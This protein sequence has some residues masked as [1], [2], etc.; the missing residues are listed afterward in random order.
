MNH[1][2]ILIISVL[3]AALAFMALTDE[4]RLREAYERGVRDGQ[5]QANECDTRAGRG[6]DAAVE[7]LGGGR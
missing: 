1:A 2:E 7:W 4:D 5:A 6:A 3:F